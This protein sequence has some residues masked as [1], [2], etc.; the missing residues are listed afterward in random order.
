MKKYKQLDLRN[1]LV[2]LGIKK[3]DLIY[4]HSCLLS[5]GMLSEARSKEDL[6]RRI[7]HTI[8][9]I[10]GEEGTI[11]VPT[12]TTDTARYNLPF[13]LEETKCDTGILPEYIRTAGGALR[14]LHPINSVAAYGAKSKLICDDVAKSNY[15]LDSPYDRMY[16]L[17]AKCINLGLNFFSNSW[18]HYLESIYCVPHIYNKLLDIPVTSKNRIHEGPFFA[19]LRYLDANV[20]Y[21]L[22]YFDRVLQ[23]NGQ[24]QVQSL[25]AGK[26]SCV[27][28][29]T[30][31]DVGLGLLK[32]NPYAFLEYTPQ[33]TP[34]KLPRK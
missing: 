3:G 6:C 13:D 27:D 2:N 15:G 24:I 30:Y 23:C 31:C 10:I 21:N 17:G 11:V 25:G 7:Y 33:F 22:N 12:F 26:V 4:M 14:S 16:K 1:S 29:K 32:Q 20:V 18:Y 34:G 19:S 5:M 8:L 28:V 9:D